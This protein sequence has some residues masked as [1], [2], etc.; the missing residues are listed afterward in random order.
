[1]WLHEEQLWKLCADFVFC[2]VACG[3][4][5][6]C[7]FLKLVLEKIHV[8]VCVLFMYLTITPN[9]W[10][11]NYELGVVASSLVLPCQLSGRTGTPTGLKAQDLNVGLLKYEAGVFFITIG[12]SW[13]S[14][15]G[16]LNEKYSWYFTVKTLAIRMFGENLLIGIKCTGCF[17]ITIFVSQGYNR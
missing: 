5:E 3:G 7:R 13:H 15:F 12:F 8:M 14:N 10:S 6:G 2:H 9:K 16:I 11:V 17:C 1:M 4:E